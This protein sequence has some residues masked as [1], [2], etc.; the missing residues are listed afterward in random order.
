MTIEKANQILTDEGLLQKKAR[1]Y[2]IDP[3]KYRQ[4]LTLW[5]AIEEAKQR[6]GHEVVSD[7][8]LQLINLQRT[9]DEQRR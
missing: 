4:E 2:H 3:E 6:S 1:Q 9:I 8:T 5:V 7:L